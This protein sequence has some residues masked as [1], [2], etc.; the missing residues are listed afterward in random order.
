MGFSDE[1]YYQEKFS[2]LSFE[3][4]TITS[5][6]FEECEFDTCAFVDCKLEKCRFLNCKFNECTLSAI[7]PGN[8]RFIDVVFAKSKAIGIDWTKAKEI[9]GLVFN[10]CQVNYS[11][12]SLL[13]IP[14][15]QIMDCEAKE[16][17]FIETE[18][19]GSDFRNTDF[20]KSRFFKTNL[21]GADFRGARNYFID[22]TNNTLKKARFSLPEA[23]ILLQSLDVIIE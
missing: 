19:S 15:T 6:D 3:K 9:R 2:R 23:L 10:G 11:N 20:E 21:S 8:S 5:R 16:V 13:K 22:V 1:S 17:D 18:L 4:E 14:K 7:Q 12:F